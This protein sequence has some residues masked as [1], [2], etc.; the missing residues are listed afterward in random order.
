MGEKDYKLQ[1]CQLPNSIGTSETTRNIHSKIFLNFVYKTCILS[2]IKL[3]FL[4]QPA[5]ANKPKLCTFLLHFSPLSVFCKNTGK[6]ILTSIWSAKH[7][8]L[9]KIY[10]TDLPLTDQSKVFIL[11]GMEIAIKH[12][13]DFYF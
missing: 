3:V 4:C 2:I 7:P 1:R 11:P 5:F 10:S 6:Y 8:M 9:V 12:N 13:F